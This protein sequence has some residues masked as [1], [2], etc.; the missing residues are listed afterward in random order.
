MQPNDT[1]EAPATAGTAAKYCLRLALQLGMQPF[2]DSVENRKRPAPSQTEPAQ[3]KRTPLDSGAKSA[4][5]K[6]PAATAAEAAEYAAA[7]AAEAA[8]ASAV[9]LLEQLKLIKMSSGQRVSEQQRLGH[10]A[11]VIH[12]VLTADLG[13]DN[14]NRRFSVR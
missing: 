2:V 8:D 10:A 13:I 1:V 4:R 9:A 6:G 5:K 14:K 3:R 7:I 12:Y 11:A